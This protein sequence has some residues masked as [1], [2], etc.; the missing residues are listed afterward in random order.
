MPIEI[1]YV[2]IAES[3][4]P[5]KLLSHYARE[6]KKKHREV[7]N[8]EGAWFDSV[9]QRGHARPKA[10][11]RRADHATAGQRRRPGR[12]PRG[13]RRGAKRPQEEPLVVQILT[14][15]MKDPSGQAAEKAEKPE[16]AEKAE[17]AERRPRRP[18]RKRRKKGP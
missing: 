5:L 3:A 10:L 2:R 11:D 12:R 8:N 16:K 15:E 18:K 4:Q 7:G 17:K 6:T 13:R 14:I 9:T 1:H